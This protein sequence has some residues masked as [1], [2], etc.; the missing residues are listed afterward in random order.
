MPDVARALARSSD[1]V[2]SREETLAK[3]YR[4]AI[5]QLARTAEARLRTLRAAG[6]TWQ[7]PDADELVSPTE[8]IAA[9]DYRTGRLRAKLLRWSM[10]PLLAEFG[11]AFDQ[12]NPLALHAAGEL[13]TKVVRISELERTAIYAV[14]QQAHGEG[15]SV[16]NTGKEM[17][18]QVRQLSVAR[19]RTI[20][21]TELGHAQNAGSLAAVRITG[22]ATLKCWLATSDNRTRETHAEAGDTYGPGSGI[23]L[24]DKFKVGDDELDHPHDPAGQASEVVNC[25]CTLTYEDAA[26]T[27]AATPEDAMPPL[28][29]GRA[30]ARFTPVASDGT[31]GVPVDGTVELAAGDNVQPDAPAQTGT[32]FIMVA[33]VEGV[34]TED[35]RMLG[36]MGGVWREDGPPWTLMAMLETSDWGHDGA[37]PAGRI[38]RAWRGDADGNEL[39]GGLFW[40]AEG[41]FDD[42]GEVGLEMSRLVGE[43]IVTGVSVDAY[44]LAMSY[45]ILHK[46]GTLEPDASDRDLEAIFWGEYPEAGARIIA[47]FTDYVI[48]MATVVPSGAISQAHITVTDQAAVTAS[49]NAVEPATLAIEPGDHGLSAIGGPRGGRVVAFPRLRGTIALREP[50]TASAA[51]LVPVRPPAEWFSA[52]SIAE[53]EELGAGQVNVDDSGRVWGI[54]ARFDQCHIGYEN[55]CTSPPRDTDFSL[56]HRGSLTLENGRKMGVGPITMAT[57]HA[58][59]RLSAQSA[60]AHYDDSGSVIADV[61]CGKTEELI[62]FAGAIDPDASPSRVRRFATLAVSGDWR[63]LDGRYQLVG[64][65]SV[66]VPGFPQARVEDGEPVSLLAAG[67]R[68]PSSSSLSARRAVAEVVAD[69]LGV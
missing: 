50:I 47:V 62:W 67:L 16:I 30:R 4:S 1:L 41:V 35:G 55:G 60:A 39:E 54:V 26:V 24:A 63:W 38:D 46:D 18:Q 57:G 59:P 36:E 6:Q 32:P 13:A 43:G 66:P 17:R 64:L 45:S 44:P 48:G 12:A 2:W 19:S 15:L 61:R 49:L 10:E 69:S 31:P 8:A 14:L 3:A 7:L 51:G 29:R 68:Q 5:L 52:P 23:P 11:V 40:W 25:R 42:G 21:I 65:L 27:A 22:A 9:F 20:A 33:A 58:D 28:A 37:K 56:Y 34:P 53:L